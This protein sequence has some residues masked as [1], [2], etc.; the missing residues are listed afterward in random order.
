MA[1]KTVQLSGDEV[2]EIIQ[3]AL[4]DCLMEVVALRV[5]TVPGGATFSDIW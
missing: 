4:S 1:K 2:R 5:L 3:S